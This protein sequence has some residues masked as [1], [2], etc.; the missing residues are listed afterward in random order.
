MSDGPE[1]S[2]DIKI[3][4][5]L[6]KDMTLYVVNKVVDFLCSLAVLIVVCLSDKF[7]YRNWDITSLSLVHS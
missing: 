1:T 6:N 2:G 7:S 4:Q 5:S 3:I